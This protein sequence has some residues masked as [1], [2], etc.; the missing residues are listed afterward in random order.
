M[1]QTASGVK[2]S[3]VSYSITLA[4]TFHSADRQMHWAIQ[5]TMAAEQW[6][7]KRDSQLSQGESKLPAIRV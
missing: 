6:S 4:P 1:N 3:A 5:S 2:S 7:T